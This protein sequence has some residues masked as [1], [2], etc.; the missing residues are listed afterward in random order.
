MV[1]WTEHFLLSEVKVEVAQTTLKRHRYERG[2][3]VWHMKLCE[4]NFRVNN[5]TEGG[6]YS[7]RGGGS[8]ER[9]KP[10]IRKFRMEQLQSHM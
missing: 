2:S 10:Y 3:I 5:R 6:R 8:R 1:G 9:R 7:S 4:R